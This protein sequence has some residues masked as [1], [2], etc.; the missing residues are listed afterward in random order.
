MKD[1]K[2]IT[3]KNITALRQSAGMTQ[4]ELA[5]RLNYSDKAV[6]KWERAESLPDITTLV[7]IAQ[8]FEVSLDRLVL[9]ESPVPQTAKKSHRYDRAM[10]TGA[11]LLLVWFVALMTFVL[12]TLLLPSVKMLWLCFVWAAPVT[13][14]VWLVLNSI[15]FCRRRNYLIISLLMWSALT[16]IYLTALPFAESHLWMLFLLGLPGQA[17]IFLWSRFRRS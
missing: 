14:V 6:S 12:L 2:T 11:C 17:A 5:E 4:L 16:A 10:I 7:A 8:L 15:W 1:I 13:A 9:D 3:A